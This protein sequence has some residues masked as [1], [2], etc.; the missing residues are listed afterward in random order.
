MARPRELRIPKLEK[1][2][3]LE[4]LIENALQNT[5]EIDVRVYLTEAKRI[6]KY[7]DYQMI[8]G[9]GKGSHEIW[10]GPDNRSFS[11]PVRDPLS[12]LVFRNLLHHFELTKE[13]YLQELRQEL[14]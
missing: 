3:M 7:F 6:L 14:K 5:H 9:R 13:A 8:R 4:T 10:T 12:Q 11:L 2:K 1:Q